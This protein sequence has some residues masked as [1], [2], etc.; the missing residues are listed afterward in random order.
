MSYKEDEPIQP[1]DS[2]IST[3]FLGG[4]AL[5]AL[6][7]RAVVP[8]YAG[9]PALQL[10]ELGLA[11]P[12]RLLGGRLAL[13]PARAPLA[14]RLDGRG[15]PP[16]AAEAIARGL[17]LTGRPLLLRRRLTL[18]AARG[19]RAAGAPVQLVEVVAAPADRRGTWRTGCFGYFETRR[20]CGS[21]RR[22]GEMFSLGTEEKIYFA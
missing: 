1:R 17:T 5:A 15:G 21:E 18:A 7:A 16:P 20:G 19:S 6:A 9:D 4:V 10:P 3:Y 11:E 12:G 14:R 2:H 22:G 13:R 8:Q